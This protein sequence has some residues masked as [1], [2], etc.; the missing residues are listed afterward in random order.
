MKKNIKDEKF[1]EWLTVVVIS[2]IVS[3]LNIFHIIVGLAKTPSGYTYLATGHYYLD[4]FEYL[5]HIATGIAGR[6]IPM[7]YFTTDPSMADW[8]FFPYILIGKVAWIFHLSP[9]T[10]YW[11]AVFVLTI[12]TLVGFYYLINL[13]LPKETFSLKITSFLI[14][15]FS[16]PVYQVFVNKGQLIL[17]PYDFWY[18]PGIFIRRFEAVPYHALGLV[19]LLFIIVNINK[20]W[21]IIPDISNKSVLIRGFWVAVLLIVLMTFSPF[22]LFSLI[23]AL[24]I[25]SAIRFIIFKRDRIK[26]FFF[27]ATLLIFIV[28]FAFILRHSVGY[29]GFNFELKWIIHP[30]WWLILLNLGPMIFFFPF[31][32]REYLKENNF[33]K[34]ILII[35]TLVS[36]GLFI[37]PIAYY[38]GT[39]NL[40]FF[41]PISYIF[42]GVLAV[43]GI[44]GIASQFKKHGKIVFI[45]ISSLLILYSGFYTFYSLKNRL[46]GLDPRTPEVIWTYLPRPIVDGLRLL[47]NYPQGNVLT[48]PYGGIG[49]FVPTFSYK[50]VYLSHPAGTPNFEK[51]QS[52]VY[53]FYTGRMPK[54]EA[55]K[56]LKENKIG[57]VILTSYDNFDAKIIGNYSFLKEIFTK[58]SIIIWKV[59]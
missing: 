6:W 45:L 43:M 44:N 12:L 55:V 25:I 47:Q 4:Y 11:V 15:I 33:L 17:N 24:L 9:V 21:K 53:L 50:K 32:L 37:S 27:N 49:M 1:S 35:F 18:G 7:N 30:E 8:R 5:Q 59:I 38:L 41:S 42:Y 52:A 40:R 58:P 28:P 14:F 23:P 13:M 26:I 57:F 39:H 46:T 48:G 34:Q 31:G 20:I 3:T 54:K 19:L 22:V 2:I 36:Y 51:K 29:G 10:A 56:F 16:G